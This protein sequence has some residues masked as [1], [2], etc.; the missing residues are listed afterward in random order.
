MSLHKGCFE[1]SWCKWISLLCI[2]ETSHTTTTTILYCVFAP[3]QLSA[4]IYT[5]G[6]TNFDIEVSTVPRPWSRPVVSNAELAD[7]AGPVRYRALCH[8]PIIGL[9]VLKSKA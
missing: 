9:I 7:E 1:R 3:D 8:R 4:A 2:I 5:T 6:K